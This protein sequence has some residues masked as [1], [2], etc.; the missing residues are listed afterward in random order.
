MILNMDCEHGERD[1]ATTQKCRE[2]ESEKKC[3]NCNVTIKPAR[4]GKIPQLAARR[5]VK[6]RIRK[7]L[8][9]TALEPRWSFVAEK[10]AEFFYNC[11]THGWFL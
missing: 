9:Y 8:L 11:K 5:R 7:G 6:R 3:Y 2:T 1:V 10:K 4:R